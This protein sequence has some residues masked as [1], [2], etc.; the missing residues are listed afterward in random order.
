MWATTTQETKGRPRRDSSS[1]FSTEMNETREL[2]RRLFY[3]RESVEVWFATEDSD[4]EVLSMEMLAAGLKGTFG[5]TDQ[6]AERHARNIIKLADQDND[7]CIDLKELL[8]TLRRI[9]EDQKNYIEAVDAV[10]KMLLMVFVYLPI[11]T[12]MTSFTLGGLLAFIEGFDYEDGFWITL[13]SLCGTTADVSETEPP[14]GHLG[15]IAMAVTSLIGLSA[16]G[17]VIGISSGPL[18]DPILAYYGKTCLPVETEGADEEEDER[19]VRKAH[20][21]AARRRES[22]LDKSTPSYKPGSV[23][24]FAGGDADQWTTIQVDHPTIDDDDVTI[25]AE[26]QKRPPVKPQQ[27]TT[28]TETDNH[29]FLARRLV[30]QRRKMLLLV[31]RV[32]NPHPLTAEEFKNG[33]EA[34][35]LPKPTIRAL[36]ELMP[37]PTVTFDEVIAHCYAIIEKARIQIQF[38]D[39]LA[40]LTFLIVLFL[41]VFVVLVSIVFGTILKF[42]EG[43]GLDTCFY[44]TLAELTG[45]DLANLGVHTKTATTRYGKLVACLI[46]LLS[47]G[48]FATVVGV[49]G[50]PLIEPIGDFIGL[51]PLNRDEIDKLLGE[52]NE[53]HVDELV[54]SPH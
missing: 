44:L 34:M 41:P 2:C 36:A 9:V 21:V 11:F 46:G 23:V 14:K 3:A 28:T 39:A 33:I 50:G 43:W 5:L 1:R 17:C 27:T 31:F 18:L 38:R 37:K 22:Q 15:R 25:I 4:A 20:T 35:G 16:F 52:A 48:I 6:D 53:Q 13:A 12:I 26:D 8:V 49:L 29:V 47:L 24:P 51:K 19:L 30:Q 32:E 10:K 7:G 40:K 42:A 45:A 54:S